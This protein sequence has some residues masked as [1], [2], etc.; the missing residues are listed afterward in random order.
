LLLISVTESGIVIDVNDK[1][2]SKQRSPMEITEFEI[3][4]D[5]NEEQ[6][7]KQPLFM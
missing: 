3:I 6:L 7:S 4:I 2:P 1:Q 5:D